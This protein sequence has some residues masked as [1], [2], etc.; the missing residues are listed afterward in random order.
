MTGQLARALSLAAR[1]HDPLPS[2]QAFAPAA[3]GWCSV[4]LQ[5]A[6][7]STVLHPSAFF[8]PGAVALEIKSIA[9]QRAVAA[10]SQPS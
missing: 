3:Q 5:G 2:V 7:T 9:V 4:A 8:L 10:Q 6:A 1:R